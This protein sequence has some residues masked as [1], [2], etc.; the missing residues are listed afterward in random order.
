MAPV[1]IPQRIRIIL[2]DV[3]FS[4]QTFL[5]QSLLSRRETGFQQPFSGFIVNDQIE[6]IVAFGSG[7]F[8]MASGV[9]IKSRS[10]DEKRVGRPTVGDQAFEDIPEHLLHRQIN[11]A[12]RR[13]NQPVLIFEPENPLAHRYSRS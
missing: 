12:V 7:I 6:D 8:G 3:D 10:I 4:G 9:L 13:K 2:K 5:P 11:P 1:G